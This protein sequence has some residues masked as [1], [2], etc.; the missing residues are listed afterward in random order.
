M[1]EPVFDLVV[2]I[3]LACAL[4]FAGFI[5]V[6]WLSKYSVHHRKLPPPRT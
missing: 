5:W 4:I 6:W 1:S 3:A 2:A